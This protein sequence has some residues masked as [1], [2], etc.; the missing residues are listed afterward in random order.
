[1]MADIQCPPFQNLWIRPYFI[2]MFQQLINP[3]KLEA[4]T[5]FYIYLAEQN[6]LRTLSF[7]RVRVKNSVGF[8]RYFYEP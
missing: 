4:V 2:I 7:R 3:I 8:V 5:N 6:V 1:M